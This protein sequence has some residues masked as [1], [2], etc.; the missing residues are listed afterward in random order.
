MKLY[1]PTSRR[2]AIDCLASCEKPVVLAGGTDLV[3]QFNEGLSPAELVDIS[4]LGALLEV[5]QA[6]GSLHIGALVTHHAGAGHSLVRAALP[7]FAVAWSRIA[8][9]RIRFRATL[10]GNLMARR[11]RYEGGLLLL[12]LEARIGY[13]APGGASEVTDSNALWREDFPRRA[14]L[15][16][17][18]IDAGALVAF[19]YE[20]S[21][22]PLM[23]QALAL[24]RHPGGLRL[25]FAIGTEYLR[26]VRLSL[27]LP[28][29]GLRQ[30]AGSSRAI[31]RDTLAQLPESFG[32]HVVTPAYARRAGAALLA[33]QLEGLHG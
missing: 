11:A 25:G 5:R 30:V 23:T 16:G 8:N 7:G 22:R 29:I 17:V 21:L 9:P 27:M 28:G 24:W 13:A 20:R 10:G 18:E 33:R 26:P 1:Q 32:D 15:E 12:A 31:A 3:A 2:E 14:L 6:G 4:K 19:H